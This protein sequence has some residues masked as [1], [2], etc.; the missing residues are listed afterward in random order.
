MLQAPTSIESN[1]PPLIKP[2][3]NIYVYTDVSA[4]VLVGDT[5]APLLGYFMDSTEWGIHGHHAF[6]PVF[7]NEVKERTVRSI[8]MKLCDDRGEVISFGEHATVICRL[9]FRRIR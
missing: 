7:Y 2:I 4:Y 6:N 3:T 8:T 9:H 5:M 1:F